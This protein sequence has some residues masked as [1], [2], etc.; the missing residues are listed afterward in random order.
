MKYEI[1]N[2][3]GRPLFV[4]RTMETALCPPPVHVD[5]VFESA[6]GHY[7]GGWNRGGSCG[8]TPMT[9]TQRMNKGAVL[10]KP[11]DHAEGTLP[12]SAKGL[13]PGV[14]R[15]VATLSGWKPEQFSPAEQ[16]E[17]AAMGGPFL[18]GE[19]PASTRI[20]LTR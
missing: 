12:L 5:A 4:P 18:R 11:G 8:I 16:A 7:G 10:L 17:L 1:V 19:V 14:Y 15:V 13:P 3:S 2:V 6:D 9:V 20:T